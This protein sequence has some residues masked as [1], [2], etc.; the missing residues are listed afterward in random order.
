MSDGLIQEE[1]YGLSESPNHCSP[2]QPQMEFVIAPEDQQSVKHAKLH[3]YTRPLT[4][5]DLESVCALENAAFTDP[6]DRASREK[7][8]L[9]L[10]K[11]PQLSIT[12]SHVSLFATSCASG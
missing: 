11:T 1:H 12:S 6:A 3:P 4:I 8:T 10:F 9:L 2:T 5:Y 7:V